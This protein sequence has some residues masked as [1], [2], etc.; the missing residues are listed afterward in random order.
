MWFDIPVFAFGCT[1]VTETLESAGEVFSANDD[2]P[3]LAGRAFQLI[4]DKRLRSSVI[5][6]Q[7]IRREKFTPAAVWPIL[8]ELI[9]RLSAQSLRTAVA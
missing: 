3:T 1:A 5:E 4:I 8:A 7:R 9:D 6:R 2:L